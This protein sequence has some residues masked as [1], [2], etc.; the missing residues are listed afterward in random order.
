MAERFKATV[1]KIV[2]G[3][4][5]A[6]S[7]N[8]T[9]SASFH[10]I[11]PYPRAVQSRLNNHVFP[12]LVSP[13]SSGILQGME[14][15]GSKQFVLRETV[16]PG[17]SGTVCD[18]LAARSGLSKSRVK[19]AMSKGAVW[20]RRGKGGLK[21]L[22][23]ATAPLV[24]GDTL[25]FHYDE[26]LLSLVPPVAECLSDQGRYSVWFKPA[27][28]VAQGT[29]YSDHCSLLRQAERYFSPPREVFL[30]HRLDRE[31]AGLM[32][33]AHSRE[34]AARLSELFRLHRIV[35]EYRVEVLGYLGARGERGA[36]D[37]PLD[38]KPSLT[39]YEVESSDPE[40]ATSVARV[41]IRTGRLHQ[42]RRHFD[43]IGHP[44][45]GDPKYGTGNKNT[46]GMKLTACAL[47]FRCP[48]RGREVE[49]SVLS[50]SPF[51]SPLAGEGG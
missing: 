29:L 33:L 34:A 26:K 7:S 32:L 14:R 1:L 38:G 2:A 46:G 45:M 5:P 12:S 39:E 49:F 28:L 41:V 6:V 25:E 19:D 36:I 42:I 10:M 18:F 23:R 50:P 35:K 47:A 40:D 9:P 31:A 30:V 43:G 27:G 24:A 51:P 11:N 4:Y 20:I 3:L 21:R 16:G 15:H 8:L 17:M 44:V 13:S 37:Q 48:F 22:R